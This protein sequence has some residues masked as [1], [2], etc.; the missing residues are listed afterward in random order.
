MLELR[1]LRLLREL[2]HRGTLT[3]VADALSFSPST[4]SQQLSQLE[5]EVGV[6]LLEPIGRRV[7]L[8]PQAHILVTHTERILEHLERAEAD[9][10]ASTRDLVGEVRVAAFQTVAL[11]LVPAAIRR[12]VDVHP[13]LVVRLAQAEPEHALPALLAREFDLVVAE[14]YPGNRRLHIDGLETQELLED[15]IRLAHPRSVPTPRGGRALAQLADHPW[16]MEPAGSAAR[17]WAVALCRTAGFEPDV[18]YESSDLVLH[19]RLV[20]AGL[21]AAL[22]PDLAWSTRR[23]TVTI[24]SLPRQQAHRRIYTATRAGHADHPATRAVRDAFAEA[25]PAPTR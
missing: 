24:R 21:A 23:P 4:I 12:L 3:A 6:P 7:R 2:A 25:I 20:E 11:S 16:V 18:R 5:T 8:T 19:A 14:E 15:P 9:I 13:G 22:L 1:R 10:A 17:T